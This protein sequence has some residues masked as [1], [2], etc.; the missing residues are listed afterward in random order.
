MNFWN[1][2]FSKVLG[3]SHPNRVWQ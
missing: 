2:R 3:N 1:R